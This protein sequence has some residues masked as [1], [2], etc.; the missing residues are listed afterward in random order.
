M[1]SQ[2]AGLTK[3]QI[4]DGEKVAL[5]RAMRRAMTPAERTLW[6]YLRIQALDGKRFRQQQVIYGFIADFCCLDE[7][8]VV[9]VDGGVHAVQADADAARDA[10][11]SS[12]GLRVLRVTNDDV[13]CR[14][15]EVLACIREACAKTAG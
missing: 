12:Q 5:A 10:V 9:E 7:A 11:F 3:G 15:P 6:H 14:L 4:I 2:R 1:A 13:R 8:L